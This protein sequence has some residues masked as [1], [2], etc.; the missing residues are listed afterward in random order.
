MG[1]ICHLNIITVYRIVLTLSVCQSQRHP[2]LVNMQ[3]GSIPLSFLFHFP[4]C[5]KL[6]CSITVSIR[7]VAD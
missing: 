7:D 1:V 4:N 3:L 2:G 5:Y 6:F